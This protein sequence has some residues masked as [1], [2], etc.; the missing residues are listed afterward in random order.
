MIEGIFDMPEIE[1]WYI[2]EKF[3]LIAICGQAENNKVILIE[4][5]GDHYGVPFFKVCILDKEDAYNDIQRGYLWGWN[6]HDVPFDI[7]FAGLSVIAESPALLQELTKEGAPV[8]QDNRYKYSE[9][10]CT[11]LLF[12]EERVRERA[13]NLPEEILQR[14]IP[15]G[16]IGIVREVAEEKMSLHEFTSSTY[17]RNTIEEKLSEMTGDC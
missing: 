10:T 6:D 17:W 16:F 3:C 4:D 13:A 2:D 15:E 11:E 5:D 14:T 12:W 8:Y 1:T 9:T 7:L